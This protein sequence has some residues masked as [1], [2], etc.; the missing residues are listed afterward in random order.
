MKLGVSYLYRLSKLPFFIKLFNWEYWPSWAFYLPLTPYL[1]FQ[2]IRFKHPFFFTIANFGLELGGSG[3]ESKFGTLKKIPARFRP[4]SILVRAHTTPD[5]LLMLL[6]E[7]GL[8][9]PLIA[10]PDIGFRGFLVKKI[11]S[12]DELVPYLRKYPTDFILQEFIERLSEFGVF[13]FRHPNEA[14]G[15]VISLTLKEFLTVTGDGNATVRELILKNSRARLQYERIQKDYRQLLDHIPARDIK[16]PLGVIGNHSKGTTF[17]NG[18]NLITP[19]L[20]K[21]FDQISKEIEGFYYGR[22]DIKSDSLSDLEQG[23]YFK[24]LELNGVCSEPTHI[25]DA[26]KMNYFQALTEMLKYW[27]II[28]RISSQ[29]K[30]SGIPFCNTAEF[31]KAY[32]NMVRFKQQIQDN[33]LKNSN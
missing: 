9:F 11:D 3:L 20:S 5:K 21:T 23:K 12:F 26:T 17:I 1:I 6:R 32:Q 28:C 31:L 18:K 27:K 25:Y 7:S 19:A 16:V 30:K 24:I 29:N 15:K 2:M 14:E 4:N 13:Y 8:T 10:K 33:N 22:F